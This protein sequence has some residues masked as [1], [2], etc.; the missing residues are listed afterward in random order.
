MKSSMRRGAYL[1]AAI[2]ATAASRRFRPS[3]MSASLITSDGA[4]RS[5]LR[6]AT[7]IISCCFSAAFRNS[8]A[9]PWYSSLSTQPINKPL[10]R[11][12]LNT[13]CLAL[14][15]SR[16]ATSRWWRAS[17]PAS[18]SGEL[19]MDTTLCATAQASGL[20]P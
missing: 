4:R 7:R 18:T 10:P 6:P 9:R 11:T 1:A 17:T 15:A 5:T 19:T 12:S 20:P 3:S 8:R 16:P 14:M 2:S 13:L